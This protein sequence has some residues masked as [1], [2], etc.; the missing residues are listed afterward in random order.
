[1]KPFHS[2]VISIVGVVLLGSSGVYAADKAVVK[3][4][5]QTGG[6]K[7]AHRY[8]VTLIARDS[9]SRH[10]DKQ[11]PGHAYVML[12]EIEDAPT[13]ETQ[14]FEA[15]GFYPKKSG[16][17]CVAFGCKGEVKSEY[18]TSNGGDLNIAKF[19]VRVSKDRFDEVK[20]V[21]AEWEKRKP[22]YQLF[23]ANCVSLTADV[24]KT[25]GLKVSGSTTGT[26]P[27]KFLLA[28]MKDN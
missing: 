13:G 6:G 5:D 27:A 17:A 20:K 3:V 26:T 19:Q 10:G 15:V 4:L 1:M 18:E 2:V 22:D 14:T 24:A 7:T 28:L 11:F 21:L 25:L 8:F 9:P 16:A 23:A 12:A